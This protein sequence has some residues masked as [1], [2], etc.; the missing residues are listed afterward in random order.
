MGGS[1]S[2]SDSESESEYS[3]DVWGPQGDALKEL[4]SNVGGLFGQTNT[5]MQGQIPGAVD[6]MNQVM[7][8][9]DPT[10]KDQM[11][12]G[13]Y[14]D[15]GLQGSLMD[16]LNRSMNN[17]SAMSEINAMIMGGSGNN[18]ADA[19]KSQYMQ[20]ADRAQKMMMSNMDLGA[21][22]A[23]Q[24][25]SSRHGVAQGIGMEG[26]N[27]ELQRNL[28]ETGFDTF[29]KDLNR[30]LEIAGMADQGTLASQQMMANMLSQQ[31]QAA[32]GGLAYGQNMQNL[33]MGQFSPYMMPWQA[34]GQYGNIIGAPTVLG[35]GSA[36]GDSSSFGVSG[37]M[38]G[39]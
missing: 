8:S 11:A 18:Y 23:G 5:G 12:G 13:V 4:Y 26:I 14:Q 6:Q 39:G 34:A 15:M 27:R 25:G 22:G 31:N 21:V 9:A 16:S 2:K 10:W 38:Y 28:A 29:D 7:A 1:F 17:P 19:M 32:Q 30:K 36:S 24:S 3:Q 37:G 35:S 33:A 20:D